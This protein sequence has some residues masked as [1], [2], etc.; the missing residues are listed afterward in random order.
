MTTI[1]KNELILIHFTCLEFTIVNNPHLQ[2]LEQK[3][4]S[5]KGIVHPE[6]KIHSL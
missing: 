2:I 5:I 1:F 4:S 3:K 6:M